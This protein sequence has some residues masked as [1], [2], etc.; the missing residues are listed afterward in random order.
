MRG[1]ATVLYILALISICMRTMFMSA[2]ELTGFDRRV[3]FYPNP[4]VEALYSIYIAAYIAYIAA[5]KSHPLTRSAAQTY[6]YTDKCQL[7][8]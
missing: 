7:C 3:S 5:G 4:S 2:T 8:K 6:I 1:N